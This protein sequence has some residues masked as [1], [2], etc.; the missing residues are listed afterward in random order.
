MASLG[1]SVTVSVLFTLLGGPCL[2]LLLIPWL[3]T[4]LH[5]PASET[6]TQRSAA[7]L[8]IVLG[9][10]ILFETMTRFIV[11]G[12]GSLVPSVP[13]ERLVVTGLYRYVRNPMYLGVLIAIAGEALL[14]RNVGVLYE[15]SIVGC[16]F[17]LFV[18]VYEEPKLRRTYPTQFDLYCAH[19][20]RWLP[21]LTPWRG[22]GL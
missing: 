11:A 12:Q 7:A 5:V 13:T 14:F 15:W 17:H 16:G 2:V 1:R 6:T 19:V 18:V 22:E 4:G 21:Q 9:L 20:P 3:L 10:A 8:V